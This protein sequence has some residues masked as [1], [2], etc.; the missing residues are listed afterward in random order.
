MLFLGSGVVTLAAVAVPAPGMNRIGVLVD[1]GLAIT[2]GIVAWFLPWN[3]WPSWSLFA[4][5][6]VAFTLIALGNL[7][8]GAN[9]WEFGLFFVVAFVW[10]GVA[11]PPL[12]V[13]L[14]LA[15]GRRRLRLA[16]PVS[17]TGADHEPG[18][19]DDGDRH[20][21]LRPGRRGARRASSSACG[22]RR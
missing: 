5:P 14:A 10:I 16:H 15:A 12:S 20:P 1:A 6:P 22:T 4:V 2:L 18:A 3:R 21:R 19:A 8:A 13:G 11:L 17:P 7:F 9:T